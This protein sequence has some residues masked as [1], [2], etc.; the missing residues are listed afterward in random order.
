MQVGTMPTH[1][2]QLRLTSDE[3]FLSCIT[4]Q[5]CEE[6][7]RKC[8]ED[9]VV[10]PQRG[11]SC[12]NN[13][14]DI[15]HHATPTVLPL[16]GWGA[17]PLH[18]ASQQGILSVNQHTQVVLQALEL[19]PPVLQLSN[20]AQD[21]RAIAPLHTHGDCTGI[22]RNK[23]CCEQILALPLKRCACQS[24]LLPSEMAAN[25][26]HVNS[27]STPSIVLYLT[28]TSSTSQMASPRNSPAW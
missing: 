11:H 7:E 21:G 1:A 2:T 24:Y 10:R 4:T 3:G 13:T 8:R 25:R 5:V 12:V 23:R 9:E 15:I 27:S 22:G 14:D 18:C 28:S 16:P 17:T 19:C 6:Q 20:F 26:A